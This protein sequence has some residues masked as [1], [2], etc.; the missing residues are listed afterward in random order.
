[1]DHL[2]D[3]DVQQPLQVNNMKPKQD[4]P[5]RQPLK[6]ITFRLPL[7]TISK[8]KALSARHKMSDAKTVRK[9]VEEMAER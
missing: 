1:M 8:I 6:A 2:F 3:C 9:A 5:A 4:K 7:D